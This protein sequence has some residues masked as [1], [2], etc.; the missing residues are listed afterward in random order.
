VINKILSSIL[1][2]LVISGC[3]STSPKNQEES[4]L[5]NDYKIQSNHLYATLKRDGDKYSLGNELIT[6]IPTPLLSISNLSRDTSSYIFDLGTFYPAFV[7]KQFKC[8]G[9]CEKFSELDDPFLDLSRL[10]SDKGDNFEQ[11]LKRENIYPHNYSP[12]IDQNNADEYA[13]DAG[14]VVLG[15]A[16]SPFLAIGV[17]LNVLEGKTVNL[18]AGN[19]YFDHVD[20]T[21]EVRA[22]VIAKYG[23]YERFISKMNLLDELITYERKLYSDEKAHYQFTNMKLDLVKY[24]N[25]VQYTNYLK[26]LTL[27][28][29]PKVKIALPDGEL[30][31]QVFLE[32][33]K[34]KIQSFYADYRYDLD[35]KFDRYYN[36]FAK[37]FVEI[38]I[39][40]KFSNPNDVDGPLKTLK[41]IKNNNVIDTNLIIKA[42]INL[43]TQKQLAEYKS[44][45]SSDPSSKIKEFINRYKSNDLAKIIKKAEKLYLVSVQNE[46]SQKLAME[47]RAKER[48]LRFA[49]AE[50]EELARK[51]KER[52][53][54]QNWRNNLNLGDNT[55]CGRV[56]DINANQTMFKLALAAQLAG[57]GSEKWV[58]KSR[59]FQP[60]HGCVNR[61]GNLSPNS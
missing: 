30:T 43:N 23:S 37:E 55:F 54:L 8:Y 32:E 9:K 3:S 19:V 33:E 28:E 16:M 40:K 46:K 60:E 44:L 42:D 47:K 39:V 14:M 56:I 6:K 51:K 26:S 4:K 35:D 52:I 11:M 57:F 2:S 34:K 49:R 58:H 53:A 18:S 29:V 27:P 36:E 22:Q 12:F 5:S 50:K 10:H 61:N 59:L 21:N 7:S 13:K 20:F 38:H 41:L 15:T 25:S 48:E 1:L 31:S 24:A 17:T 45:N